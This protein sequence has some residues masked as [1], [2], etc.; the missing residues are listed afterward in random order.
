MLQA[1]LAERFKLTVHRDSKEHAVYALV[2]GKGGPKMK[3]VPADPAPAAAVAAG[4]AAAPAADGAPAKPGM[5]IG[6]GDMQ[7][8]VNPN[9]DGKGATFAGGPFG[10]MKIAMGEGGRMR[11]EFASMSMAGLAELLSR[12]SERPVVDLTELKGNY[13]VAL[14]LSMEEM[15]NV[16]RATASQM[17]INVPMGPMGGHEGAAGGAPADAAST[18]SGSS[19]L[20][21]VQQLG[22][23]LEPRKTP[24]EMVVVD[25]V[26]KNPTDN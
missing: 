2:V 20:G 17:G 23:K 3:E 14:D 8:R 15:R 10:Q 5:V 4:G 1:L 11:M 19:V 6:S 18:P 16:A 25:H 9:A 12:F 26:E 21:A 7:V 24:V 22:L 13:E